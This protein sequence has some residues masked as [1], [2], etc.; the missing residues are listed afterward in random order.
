V[1]SCPR[2]SSGFSLILDLEVDWEAWEGRLRVVVRNLRTVR[3]VYW[4]T[5]SDSSGVGSRGLSWMDG[6]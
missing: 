2:V 1:G 5:V 3:L 4:V 6:H